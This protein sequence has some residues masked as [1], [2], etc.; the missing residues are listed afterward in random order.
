MATVDINLIGIPTFEDLP[1]N[2][3]LFPTDAP[4]DIAGYF[5]MVQTISDPDYP[6]PAVN[7][8]TPAISTT[9]QL[10]AK[11]A[12]SPGVLAGNPGIINITTIGNIKRNSGTGLADFY[13]KVFHRDGAGVETLIATSSNTTPIATST[14][15]QFSAIGLL[16]NGDFL[17]TDRIVIYYYANRISGGSNPVYEFQFGGASPVRTFL[18]VP[19]SNILNVPLVDEVTEYLDGAND[20]VVMIQAGKVK[21]VTPTIMIDPV[22]ILAA[23]WAADGSI[24]KYTYSNPQITDKKVVEIIPA[25]DAYSIVQGIEVLPLTESFGG[26]VEFYANNLATED[27]NVTILI[28]I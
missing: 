11:L 26:Y 13:F 21:S 17:P 9:S 22:T 19:A 27:F 24:Y 25:N 1:S 15:E 14:F 10:L 18:P 20:D 2:L 23:D 4:S 12:T 16:N 5:K 3:V 7:F 28:R 6:D 8:A